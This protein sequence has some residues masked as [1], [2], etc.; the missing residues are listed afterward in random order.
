MFHTDKG[1][2]GVYHV[3]EV[4]AGH[5]CYFNFEINGAKA[6]V[7]WNQEEND[8]LWIGMRD[9]D[10]RSVIRD[11]NCISKEARPYTALAMGHPEGWNDAFKGNIYAFYKYIY[12][13]MKGETVFST[14][15]EA[16]YIVK[17]TEAIVDSSEQ[18]K[19]IKIDEWRK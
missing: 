12:E 15:E 13:G 1:A 6:S 4:A 14:L 18:K 2:T 9:D 16:A 5:G 7:R 19:W 11:P 3:S 10:N 17:L 8:R